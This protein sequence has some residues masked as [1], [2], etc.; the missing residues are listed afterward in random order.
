MKERRREKR[1]K[2]DDV[3]VSG[4]M[5]FAT[6][7]QIIDVS[8]DGVSL[9]VD[10]RLNIGHQYTLKLADKS[11]A[12]SLRGTVLWS[13]LKESRK[14]AREEV[15]PIYSA[16]MRFSHTTA[17]KAAG[18]LDFIRDHRKA[19]LLL[20]GE[21]LYVRFRDTSRKATPCH[22]EDY[23]VRSIGPGG[24]LV[25]SPYP[26]DPGSEVDIE[27]SLPDHDAI[28]FSGK[29]ASCQGAGDAYPTRYVTRIEFPAFKGENRE[30][31]SALMDRLR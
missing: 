19:V 10:R 30:I 24:M 15:V 1:F 13:L 17:E 28:A 12:L 7:V 20:A 23:T 3:Q 21:K 29:V 27:L 9:K 22:P 8:V 6:E 5:M 14:G 26:F 18:L 25:A 11:K 2:L 4:G 16:G 31:F